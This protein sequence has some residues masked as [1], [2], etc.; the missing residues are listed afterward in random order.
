[1]KVKELGDKYKDIRNRAKRLRVELRPLLKELKKLCKEAGELSR[2]ADNDTEL[3][4][5][6]D[7]LKRT[8]EDGWNIGIIFK[9]RD[10]RDFG[11]QAGETMDTILH[12]IIYT[13]FRERKSNR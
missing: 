13:P 10:L 11:D 1:M 6:D 2:H 8:M 4:K 5:Y 9:L 7:V 3:Y 12:N